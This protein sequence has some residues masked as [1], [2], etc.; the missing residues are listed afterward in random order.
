MQRFQLNMYLVTL[1][2]PSVHDTALNPFPEIR[3]I[4]TKNNV[5]QGKLLRRFIFTVHSAIQLIYTPH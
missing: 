5:K 1:Y 3:N 4:C 2:E